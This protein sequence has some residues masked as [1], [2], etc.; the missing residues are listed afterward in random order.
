MNSI[1]NATEQE[2][3]LNLKAL[4]SRIM[5]EWWIFVLS[6]VFCV[7][8]A[9]LFLRYKTPMY[10]ITA[11][12]LVKDE[13]KGAGGVNGGEILG[14][15]S[16]LLNMKSNVDNEAEILKT[17][18]LMEKVVRLKNLNIIYAH[19]GRI[20]NQ[21]LDASPF[22]VDLLDIK[23]TIKKNTFYLTIPRNSNQFELSYN[24]PVTEEDT[25]R[26]MTF[27]DSITVPGVGKIRIRRDPNVEQEKEK[28]MFRIASVDERVAALQKELKVSVA[29]KLVTVIDLELNYALPVKGEKILTE[30]IEEYIRRN[31]EDKNMI[32]DSTIAFIENRLGLVGT[33][34]SDIEG[35]IQGFKQGNKLADLSEQSRLLVEN[36]SKYITR[37]ADIETQVNITRALEEYLKDEQKNKRVV[38]AS[39]LPQDLVFSKLVENYNELLL[40]RDRQLLTSTESNPYIKNLDERISA[41]RVA[42]ISNLEGT[43]KS[44]EITEAE[45]QK[46]LNKIEKEIRKV[47]SHERTYLDLARQQQIKQEL[48]LFL[49]EKREETAISKTSNIS[50][51]KIIDMPKSEFKPYS[52]NRML[53]LLIGVAAGLA[54]PF[55]RIYLL[56]ILNDKV[57]S[58]EDIIH[59][60][61]V[62]IVGEISHNDKDEVLVIANNP[63]AVIA[64][65][66]RALRT[67]LQFMLGSLN[68]KG[69][70]IL[71]TSSMSGEGKS[72]T[73]VNLGSVLAISGKKVLMMELDL[74]KPN[75]SPGLNIKNDFGFT[76]YV[77]NTEIEL[78]DIIQSA[79]VHE[80]LF[81]IP[82]GPLPPNPAEMIMN[83]RVEKMMTELKSQYDYI[84]IDAPPI[85]LVTDAQLLNQYADMTLYLVRQKY[86]Y[87]NQ[88]NIVE[89][90]RTQGKMKTI[91]IVVNDIKKSNGYGYGYGGYGY[92]YGD[93]GSVQSKKG[94]RKL[95]KSNERK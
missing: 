51:A 9:Y 62:P 69:N 47:P 17:R 50:N 65:Q 33:E 61:Q 41:M 12:V 11:K 34:L 31:I 45:L 91:G 59:V 8:L 73:A 13:K 57:Q 83:A 2:S 87:K 52:P 94:K 54:L 67:N 18:S 7:G 29:N 92:G 26:N 78:S 81:I 71:L 23:D 38:P 37:I 14:D 70:V 5:S 56:N 60:T 72:F 58:K 36:T 4:V 1:N 82:C 95:F 21:E 53:I 86:T 74:R 90:L 15:L 30:L 35:N 64:E 46:E 77:I 28:Y 75:L 85:G 93:Y 32:A 49:L 89:D 6:L 16:S 19:I 44:L 84:I 66:F 3:E 25:V 76:N 80:N 63:R 22:V 42:M 43:R 55:G 27:G 20:K 48:Y 40:E 88:L 24:N 79:G 68:T 10:K 39:V